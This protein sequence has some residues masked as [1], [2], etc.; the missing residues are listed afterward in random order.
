M[1]EKDYGWYDVSTEEKARES[2]VRR[3]REWSEEGRSERG[4]VVSGWKGYWSARKAFGRH[5][6]Q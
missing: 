5:A 3:E 6:T 4:V 1:G 2:E